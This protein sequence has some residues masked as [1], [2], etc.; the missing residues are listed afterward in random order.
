MLYDI[1][2]GSGDMSTCV[3]K[4]GYSQLDGVKKLPKQDPNNELIEVLTSKKFQQLLDVWQ[5]YPDRQISH[6]HQFIGWT[7][8]RPLEELKMHWKDVDLDRGNYNKHDTKSGKPL[9]QPM[10][11]KVHEALLQQRELLNNKL[12]RTAGKFLY[13]P[14]KRWW[15]KQI[16]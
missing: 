11:E 10:N 2:R 1:N 12:S 6:L 15:F 3:G 9:L 14:G 16:G 7:G 4:S 13:I 8:S 5:S